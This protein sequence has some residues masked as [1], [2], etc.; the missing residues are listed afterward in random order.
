MSK[1]NELRAALKA[2]GWSS[3]HV[4]VRA[5]ASSLTVTIRVPDLPASVV[6]DVADAWDTIEK[7]QK[8]R[9]K[10]IKRYCCIIKGFTLV[11]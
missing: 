4:T 11:I 10:N 2:A 1:A 6:K 8:T 5:G 9:A 7:V 3:K